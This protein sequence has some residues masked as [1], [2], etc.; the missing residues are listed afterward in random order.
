MSRTFPVVIVGAGPTGVA[1]ATLLAS[2]GV[3]VLVL[4]RW[5]EVYPQPRAVHLDDEVYRILARLGVAKEFAGISRPAQGLQLRD[6]RHRV[7]AEFRR[8]GLV[9][10]HGYPQANMFDQPE[11]ESLLRANLSK[12]PLV[13]FRG[14]FEVVAVDHIDGGVVRVEV[15]DAATGESETLFADYLLG[16]D[17]ATSVVRRSM[18]ARMQD[19]RFRQRWLV[20]DVNA[21]HD[22]GQWQ[23]VHQV[24]D[25]HRAATYM[26]ISERR[27]RWE[28]QLGEGET[29]ADYATVAQLMPLLRPWVEGPA[30]LELVRVAEYT[31]RAQVADRWRDRRIFLLGDA[32]HLTP[33]FIGQ[34]LGAG[35]RDADN[36]TWKLAGVLHGELPE[37]VLDTYQQERKPHAIHMIL[38][39][40]AIGTVMTRGGRTGDLLR[41]SIAPRLH[42]IPGLRARLL[43]SAT[44]RLKRTRLVMRR[45]RD[46]G[47]AGSLCP[48]AAVGGADHF[49]DHASGR[50]A[51]VATDSLDAQQK[52]DAASSGLVVLVSAQGEPLN[53]WLTQAQQT[54]ALVRPDG[55]VMISSD[56]VAE[57]LRAAAS[58]GRPTSM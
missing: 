43:N 10:R 15:R 56:R 54:A 47:L 7:I 14:G 11:L 33:P 41:Q 32:A 13:T 45:R 51:L 6:A 1:A 23:G 53:L 19:L 22:L 58:L 48:N 17:G 2:Y 26:Q 25:R 20:V 16:C 28:F 9:R 31:F 35:L 4:D 46:R 8:G 29:T 30:G 21:D 39:A 50:L 44:P 12:Q 27:H 49:D 36:L 18:G 24:C 38:M 52:A 42:L 55:V 57:V 3:E 37:T 40:V 34:G 5:P